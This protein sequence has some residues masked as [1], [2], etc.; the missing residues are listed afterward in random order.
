[1]GVLQVVAEP[2]KSSLP[3]QQAWLC[4]QKEATVTAWDGAEPWPFVAC[5]KLTSQILLTGFEMLRSFF[6]F[7]P[8]NHKIQY[9]QE[10]Y[11]SLSETVSMRK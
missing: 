10:P 1:M 2:H 5:D 4:I 8:A 11:F 7:F 9:K 3:L 6:F